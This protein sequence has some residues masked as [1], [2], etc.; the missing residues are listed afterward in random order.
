[1]SSLCCAQNADTVTVTGSGTNGALVPGDLYKFIQGD[2][3]ASGNRKNPNRFYRLERGK[4]YLINST[5]YFKY[6]V[7]LIA[8]E[9]D[10]TN[11]KRPPLLV[12]GKLADGSNNLILMAFLRN[13]SRILLKNI[14]LTGVSTSRKQGDLN[15]PISV[16]GDSIAVTLDNCVINAF[17]NYIFALWGKHTKVYMRN[18]IMR[19]L[20]NDHPF[21]GQLVANGGLKQDSIVMTNNTS[22]NNNSY[23]WCANFLLHNYEKIEHNTIY[24][25]M[26]NLFY[27][28]Y[29]S[30]TEIK[31]NIFYGIFAYG[32]KQIE[33]SAG[34]YDWQGSLS[35]IISVTKVDPS[36]LISNGM[37]E[38][39]RKLNVS[40]NVYFWPQKIK[41]YW[42]AHPELTPADLWMNT[43]TS[44]MFADKVKYPN[45]I[46]ANNLSV[47]PIFDA[48]MDQ[49]VLDSVVFWANNMRVNNKSTFRNYNVGST[50]ILL[51]AWPLP[52]KLAYANTQLMTAGHDGLP[53]GDLNWFPQAKKQWEQL[54]NTQTAFFNPISIDHES[55]SLKVFPNPVNESATISFELKNTCKASLRVYD[56]CGKQLS[57]IVNTKLNEGIHKYL[58]NS[59]SLSSGVY[60]CQLTTGSIS[61]QCKL[62]IIK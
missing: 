29:M 59:T 1:M 30:N 38:A 16:G 3:L 4:I 22:F 40:N 15:S 28:P 2:T 11:P 42:A 31:S 17:G 32:Q 50:D 60:I 54:N 61:S 36:V 41:D 52:E 23:L 26:V 24:T 34:W 56:Y 19:N 18:N 7:N 12:N 21:E 43:R 9:D 10:P 46:A 49:A 35:S 20:V 55:N 5:M 27:D 47:D 45:F 37:T 39:K 51:P 58:F 57:E 48:A 14:F 13:K 8:D 62:I 33:I 6:S 44:E 53:A 25:S